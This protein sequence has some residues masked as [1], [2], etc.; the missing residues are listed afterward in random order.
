MAAGDVYSPAMSVI[1]TGNYD[2]QPSA[3]V[4]VVVHNVSHSASAS[5]LLTDGTNTITIDTQTGAGAWMGVFLHCT[6]THFYRVVSVGSVSNI[7]GC[8][9]MTTK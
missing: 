2:M 1:T 6:N 8:D 5:L 4:E 9:G 3:G 7:I